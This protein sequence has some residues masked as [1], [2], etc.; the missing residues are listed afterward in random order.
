MAGQNA[1]ESTR[2][3]INT[4]SGTLSTHA[5]YAIRGLQ[6]NKSY[7]VTKY[8]ICK[9]KATQILDN[10]SINVAKGQMLVNFFFFRILLYLININYG[11]FLS[12][13]LLGNSFRVKSYAN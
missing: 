8:I 9:A 2:E 7:P 3:D 13:G 11:I 6:L 4:E 5:N 12:Y 10:L 1:N